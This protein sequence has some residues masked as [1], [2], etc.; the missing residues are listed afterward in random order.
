VVTGPQLFNFTDISAALL[1]AGAARQVDDST[2]LAQAV[3]EL[4]ADAGQRQAMGAAG[5]QLVA[6]NRGA[7]ARLLERIENYL[8]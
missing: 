8:D 5:R 7:L 1:A 3:A 4:L 2:Q 6:D